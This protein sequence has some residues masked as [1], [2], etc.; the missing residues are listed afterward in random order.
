MP[1]NRRS[2]RL[3]ALCYLG[4]KSHFITICCDRR[5]A[6]LA[7]THTAEMVRELLLDSAR[8]CSFLLH[9]YCLMPDHLHLLAHG[10]HLSADLKKFICMVKSRTAFQFRRRQTQRLWE[11][12]FYDH[13]LRSSESDEAVAHYIWCN[14][15]RK[16][17]CTS[18]HDF[19]FSGSQTIP[20]K[21]HP[22]PAQPW[23]PPWRQGRVVAEL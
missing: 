16:H 1:A 21:Q 4:T 8:R 20:W 19:P 17:L 22:I 10:I 6:Y 18:V 15:V 3:P 12:S 9:A 23:C 14:P 11:M 7:N 13:I 2:T 5:Q